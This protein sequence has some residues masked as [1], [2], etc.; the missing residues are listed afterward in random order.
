MAGLLGVPCHLLEG[1]LPCL[2]EM[3]HTVKYCFHQEPSLILRVLRQHTYGA[4]WGILVSIE[5][6]RVLITPNIS[7]TT[8]TCV[9][10]YTW[11]HAHRQGKDL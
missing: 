10:S 5:T 4:I 7:I 1:L 9:L 2:F 3:G 8:S 11:C 6:F